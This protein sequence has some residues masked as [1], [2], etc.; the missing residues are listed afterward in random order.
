MDSITVKKIKSLLFWHK[1]EKCKK[2]FVRESMYECEC[3][4]ELLLS[5][6]Y[7]YFGCTNCF[8]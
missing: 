5:S 4:D 7:Y 1:C 3:L 6:F 8:F 2:E